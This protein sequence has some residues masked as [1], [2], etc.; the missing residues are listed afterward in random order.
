MQKEAVRVAE[1]RPAPALKGPELTVISPTFNERDNVAPLIEKLSQALEG[2][3]WEVIFVD[4]NS[5]DGTADRAR[6]LAR[7]DARVR[8]LQRFGRRGLTSA[9]AEAVLA[10]SA[11]YIAIID[12][13]LQH[14]ETLL[15]HMLAA[16]RDPD[17]DVVIGSRYTEKNLSKASPA[18][19]KP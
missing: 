1:A 10:S 19:A 15:P 3:A 12:A 14:D 6:E 8:C 18:R 9:C 5:P 7:Q 2:V 4:D 13:D 11:P 17:T 16:L